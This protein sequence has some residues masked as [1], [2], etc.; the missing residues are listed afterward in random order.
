MNT[1]EQ[2]LRVLGRIEGELQSQRVD[3][4]NALEEIRKLSERVTAVELCHAGLKGAWAM[5]VAA[6][7]YLCR[8]A[9]K[10]ADVF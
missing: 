5:L 9:L 3:T 6:Y 7:M 1:I 10:L 2:I 8:Q 4:R